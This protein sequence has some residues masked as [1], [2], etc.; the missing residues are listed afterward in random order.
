MSS[1]VSPLQWS[2]LKS[3]L[4]PY[5]YIVSYRTIHFEVYIHSIS[6]NI[7]TFMHAF[8]REVS[9]V[10]V[11]L[12]TRQGMFMEL[13]ANPMGTVMAASTPRNSATN[14]SSSRWMSSMPADRLSNVAARGYN[15]ILGLEKHASFWLQPSTDIFNPKHT[16]MHILLRLSKS[17][18]H[19]K[20]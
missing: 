17:R 19:I 6:Y 16:G 11:T 4:A 1:L 12:D 7:T 20:L 5:H 15:T 13:V 9:H 2:Y 10:H 18:K 8:K 14:S 3:H